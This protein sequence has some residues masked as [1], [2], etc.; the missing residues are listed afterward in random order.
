MAKYLPSTAYGFTKDYLKPWAHPS[1]LFDAKPDLE[2][3][4]D[5]HDGMNIMMSSKP[6]FAGSSVNFFANLAPTLG[7]AAGVLVEEAGILVAQ[8]AVSRVP[9]L[10]FLQP[11]VQTAE[12]RAAKNLFSIPKLIERGKNVKTALGVFAKADNVTKLRTIWQGQKGTGGIKGIGVGFAK[13]VNPLK[14]TM[15]GFKDAE[16]LE[17]LAAFS[18]NFGG[19]F[20]DTQRVRFAVNE[21]QTEGGGAILERIES[22]RQEYTALQQKEIDRISKEMT[23][24]VYDKKYPKRKTD[25]GGGGTPETTMKRVCVKI[26]DNLVEKYRLKVREFRK[27]NGLGDIPFGIYDVK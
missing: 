14:N 4:K 2:S 15:Q 16:H 18:K 12:L 5:Y 9:G 8:T 7:I 10:Q 6:G 11:A 21:A 25:D 24:L 20:K 1:D 3:A 13:E 27:E 19:F 26:P 17:G 23:A 22:G